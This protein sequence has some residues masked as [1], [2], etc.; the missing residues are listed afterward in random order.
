[1][2]RFVPRWEGEEER[3]R[4]HFTAAP[5]YPVLVDISQRSDLARLLRLAEKETGAGIARGSSSVKR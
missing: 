3:G 2:V 4:S 1:M 5:H